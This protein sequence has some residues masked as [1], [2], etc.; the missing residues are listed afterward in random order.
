M[1][2][3][4]IR[5]K[6]EKY[7]REIPLSVFTYIRYEVVNLRNKVYINCLPVKTDIEGLFEITEFPIIV[8]TKTNE[9]II[10]AE[11]E[12]ELFNLGLR[13][14]K[15]KALIKGYKKPVIIT[16]V[17]E[18]V[19]PTDDNTKPLGNAIIVEEEDWVLVTDKQG[20]KWFKRPGYV[21]LYLEKKYADMYPKKLV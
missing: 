2:I 21:F 13:N 6:Y 20:A 4:E 10:L 9:K 12:E 18:Y 5:R 11:N 17:K 16:G 19:H 8:G 14:K 7:N 1:N 3:N 15:L